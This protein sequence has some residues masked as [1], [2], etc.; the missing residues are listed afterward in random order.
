MEGSTQGDITSEDPVESGDVDH[1]VTLIWDFGQPRPRFGN[2]D[3]V[4]HILTMKGDENLRRVL[5]F[6]IVRTVRQDVGD[7]SDTHVYVIEARARDSDSTVRATIR[8]GLWIWESEPSVYVRS[9][10]IFRGEP[11]N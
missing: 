3:V 11:A 5:G 2:P 1:G 4:V 7:I 8:A 6:T 10:E 9:W